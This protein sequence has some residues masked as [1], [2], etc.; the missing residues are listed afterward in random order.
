MLL[1]T[2]LLP[3][4]FAG[5][6][7]TL[8]ADDAIDRVAVEVPLLRRRNLARALFSL[9]LMLLIPASSLRLRRQASTRGKNSAAVARGRKG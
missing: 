9:V 5:L 1:R 3:G 2:V 6:S 8:P 4:V 7:T